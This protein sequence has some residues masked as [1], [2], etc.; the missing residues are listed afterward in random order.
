[1]KRTTSPPATAQLLTVFWIH[2][3]SRETRSLQQMN[4]N[5]RWHEPLHCRHIWSD[6]WALLSL[7]RWGGAKG[8]SNSGNEEQHSSDPKGSAGIFWPG[9]GTVVN[10]WV[11]SHYYPPVWPPLIQT[12]SPIAPSSAGCCSSARKA[13]ERH[14]GVKEAQ[15]AG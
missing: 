11:E 7:T 12:S 14:T 10:A 13:G 8:L 6:I 4:P 9:A 1:M 2:F 3:K 15:K 5:M